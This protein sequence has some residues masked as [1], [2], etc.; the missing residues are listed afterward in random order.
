M[1]FSVCWEDCSDTIEGDLILEVLPI[2]NT[3][4]V[5]HGWLCLGNYDYIVS[6]YRYCNGDMWS[7]VSM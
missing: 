5:S 2:Q 4:H 7:M 1:Y 3:I 6:R